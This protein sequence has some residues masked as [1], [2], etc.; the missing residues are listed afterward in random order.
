VQFL[1][2]SFCFVTVL[3]GGGGWGRG[4]GGFGGGRFKIVKMSKI[5]MR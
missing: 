2:H 5:M 1:Q 3:Y 4:Y